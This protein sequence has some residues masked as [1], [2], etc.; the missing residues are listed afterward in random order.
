MDADF[1]VHSNY[2]DGSFLEWMVRAGEAAGLEAIGIADHCMLTDRRRLTE[3]R[4]VAGYNLD[5]TY[6]RRRRAIE[7]VEAA[8]DITV[9]DAVEMD[10]FP[11]AEE[12]IGAFLD[13][14][15]FDYA[16]GSVHEIDGANVHFSD[17]FAD[18][19]RAARRRAVDGYFEDLEALIR[20][21][22]FDIA[23]HPDI[24][25]R[26]EALRGIANEDHYRRIAEAFADSRTIP[27][28][29]AGR[30]TDEYGRFHPNDAFLDILI[31][32]D[33][34]ITIGSDAHEPSAL[35]RRLPLLRDT[36]AERGITPAT[37]GDLAVRR[38]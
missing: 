33:I 17:R 26:N 31:E 13:V 11:D 14:A 12:R 9:F 38:F 24:V 25:E 6:E 37:P 2:S 8:V 36:F 35:E 16:I 19:S 23:A 27:E 28:L 4:A 18:F 3:H 20:S 10:Y 32:H 22:L 29:N 34:A 15:A 1:H 7:L 21:E 30:I 5:L